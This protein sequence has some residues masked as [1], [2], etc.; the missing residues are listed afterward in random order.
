[1]LSGISIFVLLF[2]ILAKA[3]LIQSLD[4]PSILLSIIC[5]REALFKFIKASF[6]SHLY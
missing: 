4:A 1:M 6:L 3:V 2:I 5:F